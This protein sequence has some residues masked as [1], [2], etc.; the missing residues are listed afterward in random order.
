MRKRRLTAALAA[1][2]AQLLL[3]APAFAKNGEGLVGETNDKVITLF[4]L[5]LVIFFTVVVI[6]GT[7]IQGRLERRKDAKSAS[8]MR[9][10]VGW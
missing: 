8:R 10:R 4:C 1:V 5:G 2:A 6:L 7:L 9:Q 3:A